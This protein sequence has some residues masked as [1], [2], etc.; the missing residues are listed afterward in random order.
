M[1][2]KLSH[3][4][5][6]DEYTSYIY[7]TFDIQNKEETS[8]SIPMN[9]KAIEGKKWEIGLI[10]GGSGSGK[11]TILKELGDIQDC[12]FDSDKALISNFDFLEPKEATKLLSSM[13]LASVP[14]WLRPFHLLSNGEQ[15]RARLAYLVGSLKEGDTLLID[16]F[17]SVVDRN[18]AKSMSCA[19]QKYIRNEGKKIILASCHYDIIEWLNPN[20]VYSP[21]NGKLEFRRLARR[22]NIKLSVSRVEASAWELFKKHHYMSEDLNKSCKCFVFKWGDNPIGFVAI[23]HQPRGGC[24]NATAF[25]RVVVLPDF[26]GLGIGF[27]ITEFISKIFIQSNFK[28]YMKT[29]HPSLGEKMGSSCLWRATIHNNKKRDDLKSERIKLLNYK[30]ALDRVSYCYEYIGEGLKGYEHLLKPI[31]EMRE[32]KQMVLKL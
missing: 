3:K 15:Y 19:L 31:G 30:N 28:M 20:W 16:E 7:E 18:V 29:I 32:S 10:I 21:M 26:Q 4:I 14:T 22:P 11:T 2:K 25:S 8:V 24:P 13:G 9:L 6:N 17:T 12:G 23:R 5:K 1:N 27:K